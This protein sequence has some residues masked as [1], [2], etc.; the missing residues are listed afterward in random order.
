M[1]SHTEKLARR[2][3]V[4][5]EVLEDGAHFRVW[6][7]D[8]DCVTLLIGSGQN[9]RELTMNARDA[10]YHELFVAGLGAGTLYR[11][12]LGSGDA[13][14]D[15]ASRFQ[16]E[17]PHGP[18]CIVDPSTYAWKHASPEL[19]A[20]S[21]VLYEMHVGTF[22][23]E[24]TWQ[25]A[26]RHLRRL[27]DLGVTTLE[28]MPVNEFAGGFGWGYDGVDLW[29]PT[30]LYGGP[31]DLRAFVDAAHGE[32]LTVIL[33]VVYNHFG[34]EGCYLEHFAKQYFTDRY[35]NEWGKAVNFDGPGSAAV[36]EFVVS[37]AACW[38]DEYRFDGLRVDAT[39]SMSDASPTHV[40]A[41][42]TS[43]AREAAEGR[44]ILLVAENEPQ[45]AKILQPVRSGGYGFDLAWND[46]FHHTARVALTGVREAYY[47]DYRG[48][49]Q[50]LISAAR[51]GY[52]FQGQ[53]YLWQKKRRG[54]LQRTI[55]PHRFVTYLENHDQVANSSLGQR[56][57]RLT[58]PPRLRAMT[59]FLLLGPGTPM[60][61]QGQ[62][63]AA[64]EPFLYFADHE[65]D[66]AK[67]VEK[68]RAEFVAQFP[69]A[70]TSKVRDILPDPASPDTFQ[71]S[72]L[73]GPS[74][75]GQVVLRLHR[76]LLRLRREVAALREPFDG[77]VLASAAFVIRWSPA[78]GGHVLLIVNLGP[79]VVL[80]P[81][82]EPLLAP[83]PESRWQTLWSSEW[84]EY[85]GSGSA[86]PE[87]DDGWILGAERALLLTCVD[88][89]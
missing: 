75:D 8:H 38:I 39:Q 79:D 32:G 9:A 60:L 58:S 21:V 73:H 56:L 31:D 89:S 44:S 47:S 42:L 61:F 63:Y 3:P 77:A 72:R 24:G 14:P 7:P 13:F 46:D 70:A 6:A 50:E 83:P 80:Q 88:E 64:P 28:V 35:E 55:E 22:T 19:D 11:F 41:E 71:R 76:D 62:E 49:P 33:D 26:R 54:E 51:R 5:A 1:T 15:P 23:S 84:P 16:P 48:T 18:S 68:G 40:L 37:N 36:R 29:A 81:A 67:L 53:R 85:G 57:H 10:G 87:T 20:R 86:E 2:R 43:A 69:A 52:L 78:D 30:R 27:A 12:R 65:A 25:S 74:T 45:E 34:P 4:G 82:P 59:A 66:L 17:G